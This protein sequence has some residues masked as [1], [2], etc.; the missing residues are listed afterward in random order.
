MKGRLAQLVE[1]FAYTEDVAGPSPAP[2]TIFIF[3]LLLY[4]VGIK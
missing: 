4:N 2:S 1:R 3:E